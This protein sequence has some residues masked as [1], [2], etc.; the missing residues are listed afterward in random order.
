MDSTLESPHKKAKLSL[1]SFQQQLRILVGPAKI[2]LFV[3]KSMICAESD[4]F[5]SACKPEWMTD[6]TN[7]VTL[8][9]EDPVIFAIFLSWVYSGKISKSSE[10]ITV[11][12]TE[13]VKD[14]EERKKQWTQLVK[15]YIM[16]EM[17]MSMNFRNDVMYMLLRASKGMWMIDQEVS[18]IDA[19]SIELIYA[20]TP[21][22]S[23]LRSSLTPENS[24]AF[25]EFL[26]DI[27]HKGI[28]LARQYEGKK[29]VLKEVWDKQCCNT[30]YEPREIPAC[31]REKRVMIIRSG[32]LSDDEN[33][34]Y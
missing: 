20:E 21:D 1:E 2:E 28:E 25:Q 4:F 32:R 18:G 14:K 11:V 8:A 19:E 27:A 12:N 22:V 33:G 31:A 13:S 7:T 10:F 15:C 34:I 16:G 5:K 3:Q 26:G 30:Y 24:S 29:L 9:E 23:P 6:G 17:L